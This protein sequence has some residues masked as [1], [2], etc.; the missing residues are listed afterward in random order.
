MTLPTCSRTRG[1]AA[2]PTTFLPIPEDSSSLPSIY[3]FSWRD[4]SSFR[5]QP[6]ITRG[7]LMEEGPS[8]PRAGGPSLSR[9]SDTP[10]HVTDTSCVYVT[11][12]LG[13]PPKPPVP[14]STLDVSSLSGQAKSNCRFS[15]EGDLRGEGFQL[16]SSS[17]LTCTPE[18]EARGLVTAET[19][20]RFSNP[21][22]V[23]QIKTPWLLLMCS[24]VT[25]PL[26]RVK[27]D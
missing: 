5:P 16:P 11:G 20:V 24:L 13:T 7:S 18:S 19:D 15:L 12:D 27:K 6:G 10:T 2:A 17:P 8:R 23:K 1:T 25:T 22:T 21:P 14:R 26:H 9:A 4:G 3:R